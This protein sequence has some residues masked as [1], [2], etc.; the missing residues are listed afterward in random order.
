MSSLASRCGPHSAS[1][2]EVRRRAAPWLEFVLLV[3]LAGACSRSAR[4]VRLPALA[5][6]DEIYRISCEDSIQPCREEATDI[7]RG[8]YEVL[9]ATGA[10]VE[11]PRVTSAPGPASTGP[12]YQRL[13]WVGQMVVACGDRVAIAPNRSETAGAGAAPKAGG[14]RAPSPLGDRLCIAGVTQECLGPGACRGA[15]AC[16]ADG[17]GYGPCDCGES[18]RSGP[19]REPSTNT[20]ADD[21]GASAP[22]PTNP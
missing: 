12:R 19:M 16:S 6:D 14:D 2:R 21:D 5:P 15:Q 1:S 22:N 17:N 20:S 9:E 11:P 8:R 10:P 18:M 13:K 7:C 3:A 4:A